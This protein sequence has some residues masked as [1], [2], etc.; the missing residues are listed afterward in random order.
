M[1]DIVPF[2]RRNSVIPKTSDLF[3]IEGIF[4]NLFN[5]RFFP[6][7]YKNSSQ[8]KVDI[9]ESEEAFVIEAELPGIQKD[10]MN[11]QI[12]EDKLT[13]SVQKKEQKDEERD[14]YIRRERSYSAMTR[15]FAIA[16]VEIEKANAKF[17][18][19]I[20]VI[21]LPKKQEQVIKGRELQID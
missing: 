16:N 15:S 7:M 2:A 10:E 6:A 18:N 21:N 11:I 13:I 12:D 9:K 4:E 3:D 5:D 20:L 19:G 14:N 1:F 17:E 8:M